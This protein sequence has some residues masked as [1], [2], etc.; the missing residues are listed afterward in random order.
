[1]Y[2]MHLV[3]FLKSYTDNFCLTY[4]VSE[5]VRTFKGICS[6]R[7]RRSYWTNRWV[8]SWLV[9]KVLSTQWRVANWRR[10]T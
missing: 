8:L 2:R 7:K 4:R 10:E 6:N 1:M 3:G 5:L 9:K